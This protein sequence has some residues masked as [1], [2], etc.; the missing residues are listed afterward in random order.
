MVASDETTGRNILKIFF[1]VKNV[2]TKSK[3]Q[4][5]RTT[6]Q[7]TFQHPFLSV[8]LTLSKLLWAA[9]N[10]RP[11]VTHRQGHRAAKARLLS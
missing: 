5:V 6:G 11:Y 9:V 2:E 7:T 3:A 10:G 8:V 4:Q 1:Q